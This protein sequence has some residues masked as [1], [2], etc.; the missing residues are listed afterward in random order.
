M[1]EVLGEM[2]QKILK[3]HTDM[4]LK[5][6]VQVKTK[7]ITGLNDTKDGIRNTQHFQNSDDKDDG[8]IFTYRKSKNHQYDGQSYRIGSVKYLNQITSYERA[9]G[10]SCTQETK[11]L[12]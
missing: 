1:F 2:D 3:D 5:D 7:S 10:A 12:N 4:Y 9:I 6:K 11:K 8:S